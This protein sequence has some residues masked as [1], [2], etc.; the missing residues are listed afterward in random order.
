MVTWEQ[1]ILFLSIPLLKSI[2]PAAAPHLVVVEGLVV[3]EGGGAEPQLPCSFQH[4]S[5]VYQNDRKRGA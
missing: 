2:P 3:F 1:C 4:Y 5:D